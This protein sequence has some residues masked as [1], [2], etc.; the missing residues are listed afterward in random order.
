MPCSMGKGTQNRNASSWHLVVVLRTEYATSTS[1]TSF[2][3]DTPK[4]P[5]GSLRKPLAANHGSKALRNMGGKRKAYSTP[6]NCWMAFLFMQQQRRAGFSLRR[7][8]VTDRAI[9]F[10]FTTIWYHQAAHI[11]I[12]TAQL[13]AYGNQAKNIVRSRVARPAS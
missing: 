6:L 9:S 3:S 11:E 10:S 4:P 13:Q 1:A 12:E 7:E 2:D 8:S 5:R